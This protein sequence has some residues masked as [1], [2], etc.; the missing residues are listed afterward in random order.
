MSVTCVV[1]FTAYPLYLRR[2]TGATGAPTPRGE[3]IR[4]AL[5]SLLGSHEEPSL[6]A[7]YI[8]LEVAGPWPHDMGTFTD[9]K[10]HVNKGTGRQR[11]RCA[12]REESCFRRSA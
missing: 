11:G 1:Y 8:G 4:G 6:N 12:R 7:A 9:N 3:G 10:F 5:K 2:P